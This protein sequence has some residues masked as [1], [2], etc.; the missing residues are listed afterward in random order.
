MV[1]NCYR[2][3]LTKTVEKLIERHT[4]YISPCEVTIPFVRKKVF[5][6]ILVFFIFAGKGDQIR[7]VLDGHGVHNGL[8]I[9]DFLFSGTAS[10][11]R[12]NLVLWK[13]ISNVIWF[14]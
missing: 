8:W 9:M 4:L 14:G 11:N 13:I 1:P 12:R 3:I 6:K 10:A 5:H 2:L 7:F